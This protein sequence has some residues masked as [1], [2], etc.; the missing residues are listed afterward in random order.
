[1]ANPCEV[2]WVAP[3]PL[4]EALCGTDISWFSVLQGT[5]LFQKLHCAI[6]VSVE[7][8]SPAPGFSVPFH[9]NYST[10]ASLQL[11]T[12][13]EAAWGYAVCMGLPRLGPCH[14]SEWRRAV[15]PESG[16]CPDALSLTHWF[17][18]P[19]ILFLTCPHSCFWKFS[20]VKTYLLSSASGLFLFCTHC[21]G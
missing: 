20:L 6:P 11:C 1:M 10:G 17:H 13:L 3:S 12:C 2:L 16:F 8:F 18:F 14:L 19:H 15:A 21:F 7:M 5:I 9:S 4:S